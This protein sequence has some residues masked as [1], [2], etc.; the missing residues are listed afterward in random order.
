MPITVKIEGARDSQH[1]YDE[2]GWLA[3]DAALRVAVAELYTEGATIANIQ[4]A[5]QGGL[6][7]ADAG[8]GD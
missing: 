6:E 4:E 5:V 8:T 7:D 1:E 3:T 2:A